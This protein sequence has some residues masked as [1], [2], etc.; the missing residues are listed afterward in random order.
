MHKCNA[1]EEI[2][3][4]PSAGYITLKMEL[5]GSS[6]RMVI[7]VK[8]RVVTCQRMTCS[9]LLCGAEEALMFRPVLV[10]RDTQRNKEA[11]SCSHCCCAKAVLHT[12]CV[13][14]ALGIQD[15]MRLRHA[16]FCGLSSCAV[17]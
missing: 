10:A 14:V 12:V 13:C 7:T 1:W 16:V 8:L 4:P 15:A 17:Q 9:F 5:A 2:A 11:R 3:A 6:E